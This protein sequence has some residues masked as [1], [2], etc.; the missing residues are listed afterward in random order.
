MG[1]EVKRRRWDRRW[2]T[3]SSSCDRTTKRS[4]DEA[5]GDLTWSRLEHQNV[6]PPTHTVGTRNQTRGQRRLT[7][8]HDGGMVVTSAGRVLFLSAVSHCMLHQQAH[9]FSRMAP[10]T[11]CQS[12]PVHPGLFLTAGALCVLTV[13]FFSILLIAVS[14]CW[15]LLY[16]TIQSNILNVSLHTI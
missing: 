4:S 3:W 7:P 8:S 5:A 16:F 10:L 14:G 11:S 2:V 12:P 9:W 13:I 15:L 6:N 1:S